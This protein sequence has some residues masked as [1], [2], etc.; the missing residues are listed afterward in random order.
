ME[1]KDKLRML[2][3]D[4]KLTQSDVAKYI[5]KTDKAVSRWEHGT[6]KPSY[7]TIVALSK[8][9]A[10]PLVY[11][12]NEEEAFKVT[13]VQHLLETLVKNGDI[14][15]IDDLDKL[16][17]SMIIAAAKIDLAIK[18]KKKKSGED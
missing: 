13:N 5:C 12:I 18:M 2:R 4:N 8:Y 14:T 11:L 10:V 9:F 6:S 17:E 7:T 1:L 16:T 15:D 3:I